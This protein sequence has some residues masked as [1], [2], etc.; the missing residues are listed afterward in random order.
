MVMTIIRM[1]TFN[2]TT[3]VLFNV[4]NQITNLFFRSC[5]LDSC[6]STHLDSARSLLHVHVFAHNNKLDTVEYI[7]LV[8]VT[9]QQRYSR[10]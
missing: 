7:N 6:L 1:M 2:K 10:R 8:G 3:T 9:R 4:I 5:E